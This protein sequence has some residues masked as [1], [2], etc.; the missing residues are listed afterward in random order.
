MKHPQT[1]F[2]RLRLKPNQLRMIADRRL[3]D[4]ECFESTGNNARA[5]GAMYLGGFVI[6]CLLKA[7]L[8]RKNAWLQTSPSSQGLTAEQRRLWMLCFR[9]HDLEELL[10]H[11][12][13]LILHLETAR[14]RG[15]HRR[16]IRQLKEVCASWTVLARYSPYSA[17]MTEAT[18]LLSTVRKLRP[19]LS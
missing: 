12:P 3:G 16:M 8:L 5:N 17:A 6:E 2:T 19:W 13:E 1:I 9:L 7:R 18:S 10:A 4:A 15:Y 11:L 14:E